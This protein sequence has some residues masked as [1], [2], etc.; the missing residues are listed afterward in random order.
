MAQ[1][2]PVQQQPRA[3]QLAPGPSAADARLVLTAALLAGLQGERTP[4]RS[5][6]DWLS[7]LM[8]EHPDARPPGHPD[9]EARLPAGVPDS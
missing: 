6:H 8:G 9:G 7:D 3:V 5:S 4:E 1:A 2:A